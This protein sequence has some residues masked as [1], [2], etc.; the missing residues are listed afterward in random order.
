MTVGEVIALLCNHASD[1][2]YL[3]MQK[4]IDDIEV[5]DDYIDLWFT[6]GNTMNKRLFKDGHW[7]Y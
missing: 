3:L 6:D 7:E 5:K 2:D 1:D 4:S